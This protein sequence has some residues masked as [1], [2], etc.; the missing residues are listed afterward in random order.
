MAGEAGKTDKRRSGD[1][2]ALYRENLV[3]I[4]GMDNGP[5]IDK[6]FKEK[7]MGKTASEEEPVSGKYFMD[8]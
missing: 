2:A 3:N 4:A 8:A 5:D 7:F 6:K 1:D